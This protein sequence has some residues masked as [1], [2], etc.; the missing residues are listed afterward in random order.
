MIPSPAEVV[1]L[2][3]RAAGAA[4]AWCVAPLVTAAIALIAW[5][6]EGIAD[7]D[8]LNFRYYLTQLVIAGAFI[9]VG[10][11]Q[12]FLAGR[13]ARWCYPMPRRTVCP[14]CGF[15]IERLRSD[16]CPE[17]GLRLGDGLAEEAAQE[18]PA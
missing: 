7:N 14:E 13:I 11:M 8:L 3:Y 18:V 15:S 10:V 9:V 16:R 5:L 6:A 1:G 17:C 12:F 4:R 2:R